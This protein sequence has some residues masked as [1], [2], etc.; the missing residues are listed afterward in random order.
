MQK[1]TFC[2]KK[3][4]SYQQHDRDDLLIRLMSFDSLT[5]ESTL[6]NLRHVSETIT[7]SSVQW[8]E[9]IPVL[10]DTMTIEI[11]RRLQPLH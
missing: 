11:L 4:T 2:K 8:T 7:N 9:N 5:S 3:K 1:S 10:G 6:F